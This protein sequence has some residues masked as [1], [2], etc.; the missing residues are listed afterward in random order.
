MEKE[1]CYSLGSDGFLGRAENYPLC[2]AMVDHDQQGIEARGSGEVSDHA[3]R[4]LLKWMR[5]TG[6][7]QDK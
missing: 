6:F 1:G 2:K 5:G 7:N 4:D 3:V